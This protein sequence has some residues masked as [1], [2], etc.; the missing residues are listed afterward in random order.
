VFSSAAHYPGKQ[1]EEYMWQKMLLRG[2]FFLTITILF[3]E[4]TADFSFNG[5]HVETSAKTALRPSW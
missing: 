2:F 3:S 4:I 1:S 5:H